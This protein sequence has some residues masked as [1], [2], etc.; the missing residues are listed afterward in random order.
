MLGLPY[1]RR[2]VQLVAYNPRVTVLAIFREMRVELD[3][4]ILVFGESVLNDAVSIVLYTYVRQTSSC[5]CLCVD[6]VSIPLSSIE[7]LSM[8]Q[9][10][11]LTAASVFHSIWVFLVSMF[12]VKER[13]T[14]LPSMI[15]LAHL[16]WVGFVRYSCRHSQLLDNEILILKGL[17]FLFISR[18][19]FSD[20]SSCTW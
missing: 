5:I 14:F 15:G 12:V 8:N 10:S 18:V 4:Y 9:A 19:N 7:A 20:L 6:N 11:T 2:E 17:L 16:Q 1:P 3:L 13:N